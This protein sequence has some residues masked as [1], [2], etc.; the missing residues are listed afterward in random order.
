MEDLLSVLLLLHLNIITYLKRK[1][2]LNYIFSNLLFIYGTDLYIQYS[3]SAQDGIQPMWE[4]DKNKKGGRWL[5]NLDKK[6][7]HL[8][9]DAFWLETVSKMT[10]HYLKSSLFHSFLY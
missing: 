10:N 8:E 6:K 4:D 3:C 9:L 7:R 1:T 2:K 5:I